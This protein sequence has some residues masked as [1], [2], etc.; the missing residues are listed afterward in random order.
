[1][2][3]SNPDDV[4]KNFAQGNIVIVVCEDREEEGDFFVLGEAITNQKINF[5]LTYGKGLICTA[6][7]PEI[8][9]HFGIPLMVKKSGDIHGTN[10]TISVDAAKDITTG[11]SASDRSKTIQ[12]LADP[13][14]TNQDLVAPGHTQPLR[15]R[16]PKTRWGHTECSVE[17]A[18]HVKKIPV[19]A[20]CEILNAEGEKASGAELFALAEQFD[21]PI[22]NLKRMK[23]VLI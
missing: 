4:L 18:K 17:M 14:A 5:M 1:M 3:Y 15:A 22:T 13:N 9:D 8:L 16:N 10:F 6:C 21:L 2:Q 11:V 23:E 20:I 19:V 7:A 12:V